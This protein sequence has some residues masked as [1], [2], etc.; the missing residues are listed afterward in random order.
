MTYADSPVKQLGPKHKRYDHAVAG[1]LTQPGGADHQSNLGED[2]GQC[3]VR[4][5]DPA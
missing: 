2:D 1:V 5:G 4:N 3:I